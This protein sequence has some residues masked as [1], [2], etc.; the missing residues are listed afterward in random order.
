MLIIDHNPKDQLYSELIDLAFEICDEFHLV[1]RKD[2]GSLKSF[3]P[4]LKK[5]ESSLKVMKE[6]SEWASTILGDN[7]KAKVYYYYTDENAKNILKESANSLYSWEQPHLPEDLSFFKD[8]KEWLVTCSHEEESYIDTED[9]KEIQRIL[10]IP[11]LKVHFER[12]D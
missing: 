11:G 1:L 5:L 3:D 4:L 9:D 7:Q 2:M 8:G 6:Q 10:S 12:W